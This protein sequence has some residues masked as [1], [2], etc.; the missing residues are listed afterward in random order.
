MLRHTADLA[1]PWREQQVHVAGRQPLIFL[2]KSLF[3]QIL[4]DLLTI[5]TMFC[6]RFHMIVWH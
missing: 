5:Y 3:S 1:D 4:L 2:M 6:F